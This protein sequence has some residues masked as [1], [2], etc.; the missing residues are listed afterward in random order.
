MIEV[1]QNKMLSSLRLEDLISLEHG[2]P[3][4]FTFYVLEDNKQ[5]MKVIQ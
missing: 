5:P 1:N 3:D 2:T 4:E